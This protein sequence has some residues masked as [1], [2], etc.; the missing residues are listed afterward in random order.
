MSYS[1]IDDE[2][3]AGRMSA[4]LMA[5]VAEG[6]RGRIYLSP[7]IEME[8]VAQKALPTWKPDAPSRGTWASNAQ[9][10]RYGFRTFGDYFTPRQLVAL[11]T[12][13]DLVQEA[14]E[15]VKK[16]ALA[17]GMVG[18][19]LGL[20]AGGTGATAYTDAMAVYLAFV[21]DKVADYWSSICSWHNSGE[22]MRNTFGRQAIQMMWDFA[23]ANPF[24]DSTGNWMAMVHWAWKAL[25]TTPAKF[26]GYAKQADAQGQSLSLSRLIS[27]DPPYFFHIVH[28]AN[29]TDYR[30]KND[31][32]NNHFDQFN[33]RV[34]K[35]F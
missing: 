32:S 31:G 15:R 33:E 13:S 23:E 30:T 34:T 21:V 22:K 18:D 29:T 17:A 5:I 3:N 10:R 2:A 25:E 1:Y 12:F 14:R 6:Q 20:D 16:D 24:C 26:S 7:T 27:T 28:A 11:T 19:G 35:W 4:R 9:G 8:E